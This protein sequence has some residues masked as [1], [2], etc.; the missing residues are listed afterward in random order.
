MDG[1]HPSVNFIKFTIVP[2]SR[3]SGVNLSPH[4]CAVTRSLIT[5]ISGSKVV[6]GHII[7]SS[8]QMAA[9]DIRGCINLLS[10]RRMPFAYRQKKKEHLFKI[11][12]QESFV[13]ET[14]VC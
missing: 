5:L 11:I 14:N 7:P 3:P 6:A 10:R 9:L 4:A 1:L 12:F 13:L 2:C 8:H